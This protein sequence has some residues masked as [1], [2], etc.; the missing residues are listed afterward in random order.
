MNWELKFAVVREDPEVETHLVRQF[1]AKSTLVVASG[2][3]T[4]LHLK[5]TFPELQ[6]EAYDLN[7]IQLAHVQNKIAQLPLSEN[8]KD[9]NVESS[10]P[11]GLNQSGAFEKLFRFLRHAFLEWVAPQEDVELFFQGNPSRAKELAQKWL[12]ARYWPSL[13]SSTFND[14]ILNAM[15]G[16]DA[17]QHAAPNSYPGYFQSVFER[18]LLRD[19][20]TENPFLQHI[21]LGHYKKPQAPAYLSTDKPLE[22]TLREGMLTDLQDIERFDLIH[23]SNIFDWSDNTVVQAWSQH[24]QKAKTGALVVIRQLNNTRTMKPFFDEHFDLLKEVGDTLQEQDR[25]LFY[26]RILVYQK[27]PS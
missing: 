8:A 12:Q 4:A 17:T 19:D 27:K 15:F 13:F 10:D 23:L 24:L 21:F 9:F 1:G 7:P 6:V 5:H 26:N 25:S 18:G 22:I 2:G 3:C 11:K 16:P 14:A 20:A